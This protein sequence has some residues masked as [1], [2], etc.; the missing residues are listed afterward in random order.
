[1]KAPEVLVAKELVLYIICKYVFIYACVGV[2]CTEP[3]FYCKY[4]KVVRPL[5]TDLNYKTCWNHSE[6]S[7]VDNGDQNN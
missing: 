4:S 7:K 1:M 2:W 6:G 5:I 3:D